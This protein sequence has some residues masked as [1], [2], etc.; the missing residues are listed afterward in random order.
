[1]DVKK[2]RAIPLAFKPKDSY[3]GVPKDVLSTVLDLEDSFLVGLKSTIFIGHFA[4]N[5]KYDFKL[6]FNNYSFF[7][8]DDNILN[9]I[10]ESEFLEFYA[11]GSTFLVKLK[12]RTIPLTNIYFRRKGSYLNTSNTYLIEK[13]VLS[14]TYYKLNSDVKIRTSILDS[15]YLFNYSHLGIP[16]AK[17]VLSNTVPFIDTSYFPVSYEQPHDIVFIKW[18]GEKYVDTED[19]IINCNDVSLYSTFYD[20]YLNYKLIGFSARLTNN[21]TVKKG[22]IEYPVTSLTFVR[23]DNYEIGSRLSASINEIYYDNEGYDIEV[24]EVDNTY[25]SINVGGDFWEVGYYNLYNIKVS[26]GLIK[27]SKPIVNISKNDTQ[28]VT[29]DIPQPNGGYTDFNNILKSHSFVK[30]TPK[31]LKAVEKPVRISQC[32]DGQI[33]EAF[34]DLSNLITKGNRY[35]IHRGVIVD[36]QGYPF[37]TKDQIFYKLVPDE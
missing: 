32:R 7:T 22:N 36:D 37:S 15:S 10:N 20:V 3:S 26:E 34:K 6:D 1:M 29:G 19:N 14:N 30:F 21:G 13:L 33:I 23:P 8:K 25:C 11:D 9:E 17:Y 24:D 2:I 4:F 12:N 16:V 28:N 18:D 5:L 31:K 27:P 35:N